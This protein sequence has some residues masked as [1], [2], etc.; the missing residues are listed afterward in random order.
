MSFDQ[1]IN[2]FINGQQGS[3]N[4]SA[5]SP[6]AAGGITS[7]IPGGLIGG[8]AAGGLLG[9]VIGNKKMRK[10][11]GKLAGGM[12]G[13]GGAALLGVA[14]H[15]AYQSWQHGKQNPAES[16]HRSADS[17][18][19]TEIPTAD[20]TKFDPA[21]ITSSDGQPFQLAL[22][23]AM[24][25]AAYADGH[26]D[27]S[28]YSKIFE[29]LDSLNMS[30]N[31]KAVFMDLLKNPPSIHEIADLASGLEQASEIYLVSRMAID[32][33]LPSERAYL[34]DLANLMEMPIGLVAQLE[35]QILQED[36]K[37]A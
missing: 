37:A 36:D 33:D 24:V 1:M 32:P 13:L 23:K 11:A 14:A 29:A 2:Q 26:V 34:E 3:A 30:G 31:E 7:S 8:L 4:P 16:T 17:R 21:A 27:A 22:V 20:Y 9:A 35:S 15:K 18:T 28:E 19:V 6:N 25:A 10:S 12:V 5:T